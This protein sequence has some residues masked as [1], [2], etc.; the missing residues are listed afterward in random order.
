VF[1]KIAQGIRGVTNSESKQ[2][3]FML[4]V[5][6]KAVNVP[7]DRKFFLFCRLRFVKSHR[8]SNGIQETGG[9]VLRQY[10]SEKGEKKEFSCQVSI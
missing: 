9:K 8:R 1:S 6:C 3:K 7:R 5:K 4:G 2:D 10:F